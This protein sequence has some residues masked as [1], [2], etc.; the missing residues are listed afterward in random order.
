MD[1]WCAAV[2]WGFYRSLGDGSVRLLRTPL[3]REL[4]LALLTA[5][6]S[7]WQIRNELDRYSRQQFDLGKIW[8]F[9]LFCI[10]TVL[11]AI[12]LGLI[13]KKTAAI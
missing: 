10:V 2:S 1:I 7:E 8:G 6:G 11:P 12:R 5:N 9:S 4:A 13:R 3:P